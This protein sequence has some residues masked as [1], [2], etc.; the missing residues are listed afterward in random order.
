[1]K[2]INYVL[3][4]GNPEKIADIRPRHR[5][6]MRELGKNGLL[7]AAGPFADG[8]G[9]LFIYEAET[10]AAAE[11]IFNS[12]PYLQGDVVASYR[13]HVWTVAGTYAA[14]IPDSA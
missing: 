2:I 1:M 4:V 7:I 8:A 14:L 5:A 11:S 13:M 10:L 6:Y 9:A 12:D 3:Y